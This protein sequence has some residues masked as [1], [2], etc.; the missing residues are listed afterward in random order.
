MKDFLNI[1]DVSK[2]LDISD[3]KA[4]QLL[5]Y[6]NIKGRKVGNKWITTKQNIINYIDRNDYD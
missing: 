3:K 4:R 5:A 1:N 2:L 6:G